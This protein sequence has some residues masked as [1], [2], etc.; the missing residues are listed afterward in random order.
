MGVS[1]APQRWQEWK[2]AH[3]RQPITFNT[4]FTPADGVVAVEEAWAKQ[5][6]F[7]PILLT[8]VPISMAAPVEVAMAHPVT[9]AQLVWLH[10]SVWN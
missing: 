9:K 1:L 10:S 8:E 4:F 5:F 6:S 7:G 2:E 3:A